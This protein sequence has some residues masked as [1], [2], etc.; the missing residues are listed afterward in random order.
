MEVSINKASSGLLIQ[1]GSFSHRTEFLLTKCLHIGTLEM[2]DHMWLGEAS[3]QEMPRSD[4]VSLHH[5]G[6]SCHKNTKS[7]R[8]CTSGNHI[9]H[10]KNSP[11]KK[12]RPQCHVRGGH[13]WRALKK[14]AK[15]VLNSV[16]WVL[17]GLFW[18]AKNPKGI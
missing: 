17:Y 1:N 11:L 12:R 7:S 14:K 13:K 9:T 6:G 5:Y 18:S 16:Q 10:T 15:G 2:V 8:Y 4:V 3:F